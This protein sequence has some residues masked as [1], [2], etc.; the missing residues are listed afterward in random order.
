MAA[1]EAV[2]RGT[3]AAVGLDVGWGTGRRVGC[4]VAPMTGDGVG[5]PAATGAALG[6]PGRGDGAN[7]GAI[8]AR[9]STTKSFHVWAQSVRVAV[10]STA[11]S[12][13][14]KTSTVP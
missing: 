13:P 3:G 2:G 1:V 11:P 7:E 14:L 12:A 9:E 8:S 4:G 10:A 5:A 6:D